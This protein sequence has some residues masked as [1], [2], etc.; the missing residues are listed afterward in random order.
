[1][2]FAL[3][4]IL[5]RPST[6]AIAFI[7]I[8]LI[9]ALS[10]PASF[11]G[12]TDYEPHSLANAL[13]LSY[14]LADLKMYKAMGM[15]NHPGVPF[16]FMSWLAL[17]L[18]GHPFGSDGVTL[19]NTMVDHIETFHLMM[20]FLAGLVGAAGIFIFARTAPG[21]S[22]A[23]YYTYRS[24]FAP[25]RHGLLTRSQSADWHSGWFHCRRRC[26]RSFRR[27]WSRSPCSSMPCFL[28]YWSDLPMSRR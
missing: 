12:L 7:P 14:R 8:P 6:L 3:P 16:Y 13:N 22:R 17:A 1:M 21:S 5:C 4:R 26:S 15:S 25:R 11:W 28:R 18:T 10:Y 24:P 2:K 27:E 20:I 19:F 9:L 23:T